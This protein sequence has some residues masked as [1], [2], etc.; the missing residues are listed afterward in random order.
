M[1]EASPAIVDVDEASFEKE[2]LEESRRRPVVVDFWASWCAPC[3]VVTPILEK[4]AKEH[5][6]AFRLAK[7]N[8]DENEALSDELNVQGIPALKAV[9]DGKVVDELTGALPESVIRAWLERFVPG[10]A[11]EAVSRGQ[12]HEEEGRLNDASHAYAEALRLKPRHEAALVALA[13]LELAAGEA[14]AAERHLD[15]ILA[16]DSSKHASQIAEL[17]LRIRSAGAGDL[18]ELEERVRRSPDD[19]E[20]KVSLGKALAAAG[21]HEEA[22]S[23]LLEVVR[24]SPR[25]GPGEEARLAM[26]DVF[27]VIGPRSELADDF[28]ARMAAALYR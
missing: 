20:A 10:P 13:R 26:L 1:A 14:E 19:L 16:P 24:A 4:L 17:R 22:L 15:M 28:R 11:D 12:A 23:A 25:Q 3:R 7:V 8:A 2:V 5:D 18:S 9:R 21:R 27:G 6:G